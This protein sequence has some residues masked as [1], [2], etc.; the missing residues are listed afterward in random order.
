MADRWQWKLKGEGFPCQ[1]YFVG[2]QIWVRSLSLSFSLSFKH[3]PFTSSL[4][5]SLSVVP[6]LALS[7]F[8]SFSLP[9]SHSISFSLSLSVCLSLSICPSLYL[10]LS[11]FSVKSDLIW[12][13]NLSLPSVEC[14]RNFI[15]LSALLLLAGFLLKIIR[16]R[17]TNLR[18]RVAESE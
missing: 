5:H 4:S 14:I 10:S 16:I 12:I 2:G 6:S 17:N 18:R 13:K 15:K 9:P 1:T 3:T 7:F 8:L 11:L